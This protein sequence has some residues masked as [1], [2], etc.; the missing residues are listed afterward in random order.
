MKI[1][2]VS[3]PTDSVIKRV[4][5]T[6]GPPLSL[7]Y[8]ASMVRDEHDV[9]IVDSIAEELTFDDVRKRI[10]K[11]DPDVVGITATTSMIPD[12]YKVAE[13]AK[14]INE[15]VK[16]V[17]GGPHVTFLPD[18]TMEE[19]KS[20][21]F[22][23]RGEGEITFRE[24]IRAIEKGK[25]FK[26][27][28]GLSF[29]NGKTI[30]NNPPRELIKNVDEIPMPSYDLLPMER[31]KADGVK[32]GTIVTSR[33]C[34]FNCIFCSSSLQFG[35]KWRGHSPERVIAELSIL[36]NEYG[37]KSIEFLDDTFTL[38]KSRA[39]EISN[40]I[41]KEGL[42]ISWVASSRVD[43]FSKDVAEAMHRAGAHTVYFGI[44]SGT[45]KILDFIGKGITLEQSKISVKNAKKAGLHTFG[46]F[47]I[48][49]PQE[50]RRDVKKTL[51]FSRKVGVDFA[52]F[53]LATPY[54]GTRLWNMALKEKLLTTMDWRKFTTLDPILKLKHFT[55]EQI[56]KVLRFAYVKFYL[57]PKFLIKDIIQDKGFIIR[58][59][60]P[61]VIKM[62]IQKLKSNT[63]PPKEM[64]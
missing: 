16:V 5:G 3:P 36:R 52:Q 48:G 47:I 24:L 64:I 32:F 13:I 2:L 30:I 44:E 29:R 43:T 9:I 8:L 57:R 63:I 54:P 10:K 42:D 20:I 1:L 38:V 12:A 61:Q 59:A 11:F 55:R 4:V 58:R 33:G 49:F 56:L 7:A 27:I 15:N 62:Y 51:K 31:Y 19:C 18:R 26:A 45:Q 25:D 21:D 46:S 50:S 17:I 28:K 41:K 6:T 37:R 39:I 34:P 53:T 35:R 22:I 40:K 23:V 14:E 60:I